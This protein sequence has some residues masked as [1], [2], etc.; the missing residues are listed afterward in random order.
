MKRGG[1]L[2]IALSFILAGALATPVA[3]E[4]DDA[5]APEIEAVK[6]RYVI[7]M[8]DAPNVTEFGRDGV[9]SNAASRRAAQLV[10]SQELVVARAGIRPS[11]IDYSYTTA[12]N[13][14][15][16]GLSE[17]EVE[18]IKSV[19]GVLMVLKDSFQQPMTDSSGDFLNLDGNG[20]AWDMG[21]DGEDVIV[22]V[23][24][25]GIWP[26]HPSF[27]DD[28]SYS[29]LGIELDE[30]EFSACDFGNTA[31]NADDVAFECN[32]KLLG[33]RQIIPIY[34][35]FIGADADEF[36]SARDDDGHGTHTAGTAAGNAGVDATVLGTEIGEISGVA[37]R[38][39]VIAYKGL[40]K[41]GGFTSDLAAAIDYAV[42]DGVDVINYSVGGGV[43]DELDAAD[44]AYLFA[45]DAGVHVA[46]SAGNS[47]PG[48]V[49]IGSPANIPWLTTV[50]A[51]TQPRFFQGKVRYGTGRSLSGA[52][53]TEGTRR[54]PLVDAEFAGGDLCVP[55]TLDPSMVS[56]KIVLCRRGAIARAAKSLA[57]LEAGGAGMVL[58]NNND[59]DNLVTDTH[60]VPSVH[61]DQTE[62][63]AL[64][65]YIANTRRPSARILTGYVTRWQNAPTMAIFSSRGPNPVGTDIIKP[66]VTAPGVQIVAGH[67]P[68]PNGGA[69]Q[70][71][72]FQSIQGTSMSSPH[73]AGHM[74][75]LKQVHPDW[76]AAEL[77]S[78]IMTTAHQKVR[79][80]DRR[81]FAGPFEFGAGHIDPGRP[82]V[83]GSSFQPGLVYPAGYS[84]Y[85][86][87]MCDVYP[88]AFV[89]AAATCAELEGAGVPTTA[90]NLNYPSIGVS[91]LPGSITVTRTVKSVATDP[92][93]VRF[94]AR[95]E[96]PEGYKVK[97][98]PAS[99]R[100]AAGEEAT[101]QVT[102]TNVN[103]PIGE[104]RHGAITWK[105][106]RYEVR[107]PIS[108]RGAQLAVE[109]SVSGEGVDGS[110][111]LP[112]R[113]G[114]EG[115][116]AAA[117]HGLEPAMVFSDTVAQ[118]PDQVFDPSDV[119]AG[120]AVQYDVDVDG[121]AL[122]K[123]AMPPDAVA[124][125]DID[126]D[127]F[128]LDETGDLI[129]S[130]TSG[131]TNEVVEFVLPQDG[132]YSIFVHGWQTVTPTTDYD[133]YVWVVSATPGGNLSVSGA[134]SSVS[135]GDTAD[136]S[137]SWTGA[138][139]GEWH[140]GAISHSNEDG[141]M[142][143]TV[144]DVDNR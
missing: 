36:D 110:G 116:Y 9:A 135:P 51:S 85:L 132:T 119:E 77:K 120:G 61:V 39:R 65:R 97:V 130:S 94:N 48:A 17:A 105:R 4:A 98:T 109:G 100:L 59:V 69:V 66:D 5:P 104:W 99:I 33:A 32:N 137:Y 62:G 93:P 82:Q 56:G 44:I 54:L 141:L 138:A 84:D 7:V 2:A 40:G 74:A 37:P 3:A 113:F 22:G 35:A 81:T 143:L 80:N 55:G 38:A 26:E 128:V 76:S 117:G 71:E 63:L 108:V 139:A 106:G 46:T 47:G 1:W 10:D 114:Y 49:T 14:F 111:E 58:Y 8:E 142:T 16:I 95:V 134:P 133:L 29:D 31:H 126:L 27:A 20:E 101:F 102:I 90:V 72:L 42:L 86:G 12:L 45:A 125:S 144:V 23:I 64:K 34:R 121:A 24:D 107:S 96:A 53:L 18:K 78:A 115:D 118:D 60:A 19:D 41:L 131:G 136:L 68:M 87:F 50:G 25:S 92:V 67:T 103:A 30:S 28:G 127:I 43:S 6:D 124:S 11:R 122:L 52:S 129:G 21:V 57:V 88:S 91:S 79:D 70:G 112:I 89:D 13:G 123:I 15:A 73:V 83:R 140:L 75:L